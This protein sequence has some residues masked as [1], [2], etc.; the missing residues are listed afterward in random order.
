MR[1]L[2]FPLMSSSEKAHDNHEAKEYSW[3]PPFMTSLNKFP[4]IHPKDEADKVT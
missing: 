1:G 2:L 4:A 3:H